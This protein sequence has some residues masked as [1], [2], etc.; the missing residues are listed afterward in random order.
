MQGAQLSLNLP[1]PCFSVCCPCVSA[2]IK[3]EARR[4]PENGP[5]NCLH[6]TRLLFWRPRSGVDLLRC[7]YICLLRASSLPLTKA[8]GALI[9]A[10]SSMESMRKMCKE[11]SKDQ[12]LGCGFIRPFPLVLKLPLIGRYGSCYSAKDSF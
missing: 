1:S 2:S 12:R 7:T 11:E 4:L 8:S 6:R 10:Q 3:S 5:T 9:E